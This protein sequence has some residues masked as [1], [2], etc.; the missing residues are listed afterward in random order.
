LRRLRSKG[1]IEFLNLSGQSPITA[2]IA[3][4]LA[5]LESVRK[6]RIWCRVTRT[7]MR[8]VIPIPGLEELDILE[9]RY[10]GRLEN[11]DVATGIKIFR[12]DFLSDR[13]LLE[14]ARLPNLEE[15]W[16]PNAVLSAEVMAAILSIP[17]LRKLDLEATR[18]DNELAAAIAS[19]STIEELDIGATRMTAEGLRGICTMSQLRRLDIWALDIQEADLE[20]LG[21]L[22][23]LEYLIVGGYEG[24]T[25]L[26]SKGVIPR[27][28]QLSSLRCIWLDGI[29]LSGTE[30]AAL[31]KRFE[32]VR[33]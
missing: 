21:N 15:L 32:Y 20:M 2:K 22:P 31:K 14:I 5:A 10:P 33:N 30:L 28:A 18:L 3:K 25:T 26:T 16:A 23:N 1:R 29:P 13:D 27:L 4:G 11:F 9:I 6:F 12:C 7:A 17:K 8:H 19:S 24:Q